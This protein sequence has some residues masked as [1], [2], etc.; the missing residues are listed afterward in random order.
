MSSQWPRAAARRGLRRPAF[1]LDHPDLDLD[2]LVLPTE[3]GHEWDALLYV[4]RRGD[5]TR[6]RIAVI[7]VH[8]S[9]GNYI[10]GIPRRVSMG[11]AQDG[12]TV[13]AVNTRMANYGAFFGGGLLHL[14]PLDLDAAMSALRRRGYDRIVLLGFSMGATVVTHYQALRRPPEVIGVCTLAHPASLVNSLRRRWE[15]YGAEPGYLEVLRRA[16]AAL[17][18][19]PDIDARGDRGDEIFVVRRAAGP[20]DDPSHCEIWT[21]RTWWFSRG[22]AVEHLMSRSRIELV[23]VPVL[24]VQAGNDVMVAPGEGHMLARFALKGGAP[25]ADVVMIPGADHVFRGHE[26]ALIDACSEWLAGLAATLPG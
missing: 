2:L 23:G 10:S 13:L 14:T 5:P 15:R 12:F 18:P 3:D 26:P 8:G 1:K 21:H 25:R 24:F 19:V 6:R 7:V 4:P 22:P 17:G 20:T 9:V 16:R 11:L